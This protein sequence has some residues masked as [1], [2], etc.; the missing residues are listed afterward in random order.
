MRASRPF[1][2]TRNEMLRTPEVAAAYLDEFRHDNKAFL[3]ALKH[4]ADA[5]G[6][7]KWLAEKSKLNRETL[8]TTLSAEGN[9]RLDTLTK[10]LSSMGLQI[11][12]KPKVEW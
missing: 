5:N 10:V 9:P 11:T 12:V 4:V 2:L 6:G 7:M 1:R 3:T 8:F